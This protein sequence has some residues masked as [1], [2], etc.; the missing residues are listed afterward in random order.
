MWCIQKTTWYNAISDAKYNTPNQTTGTSEMYRNVDFESLNRRL[1]QPGFGALPWGYCK[2]GSLWG[3]LALSEWHSNIP[4][5]VQCPQLETSWNLHFSANHVGGYSCRPRSLLGPLS[6]CS[7]PSPWPS[8]VQQRPSL[9]ST[10]ELCGLRWSLFWSIGIGGNAGLPLQWQLVHWT[11]VE[12]VVILPLQRTFCCTSVSFVWRFSCCERT[13]SHQPSWLPRS[14]RLVLWFRPQVHTW[15]LI[16]IQ[17][18][19]M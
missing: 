9:W 7:S 12:S 17:Y 16:L 11:G 4:H 2:K 6:Y 14:L 3:C 13:T 5:F 18:L 10:D 8:C 19:Q 15:K 1:P